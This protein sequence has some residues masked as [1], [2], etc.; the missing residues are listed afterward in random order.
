MANRNKNFLF[1]IV[2]SFAMGFYGCATFDPLPIEKSSFIERTQSQTEDDILVT[3]AVLSADETKEIFNLD[4]YKKGIQ[5]IW[6]EVENNNENRVWFLP[7]G[8]DPDYYAPLE[9]AYMNRSSFS[10]KARKEMDW[11]FHEHS[12]KRI[13]EPGSVRSGF[14]FTH[15]DMGTKAFNVDILG[16]DR[17][18]RTFTFFIQV[19]G[20]K[21]SHQDVDWENLYSDGEILACD[22]EEDLKIALETLPMAI[23]NR[24][25]MEIGIPANIVL[26]GKGEDLHYA[27]IRSGWNETEKVEPDSESFDFSSSIFAEQ[28]Q[29]SPISPLSLFGRPQ[30]AAFRKNRKTGRERNH[31]RLWLS[32]ITYQGKEVWIGQITREIKVQYIPNMFTLEPY[33][34]EVRTYLFQDMVYSQWVEKYG[35]IEGVEPSSFSKP[36]K[37]IF[38]DEYFTD[39]LRIVLWIS[40]E[41]VSF[42]EVKVLDW[43]EP[44]EYKK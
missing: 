34:D 11:Y 14:I 5:P 31:L 22:N 12:M 21:V 23:T 43:A 40:G 7:V 6:I 32:P 39:G 4:L 3:A 19:P 30:D 29:Y 42:S 38:G 18:V 13:I 27:L 41:P 16:V 24:E 15:L 2:L 33:I 20:M 26:I 10:K 1:G 36:R 35:Y 17:K 9:V 37:N 44:I 25:E 8:V 28:T